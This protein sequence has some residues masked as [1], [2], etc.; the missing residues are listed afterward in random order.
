MPDWSA[1]TR[2]LEP[3]LIPDQHPDRRR[4]ESVAGIVD[5]WAVRDDE[6]DVQ[7]HRDVDVVSWSRNAIY[8]CEFAVRINRHVHEEVQVRDDVAFGHSVFRQFQNEVFTAGVLVFGG[9]A[10]THRVALARATSGRCVMPPAG[11][12]RDMRH[13]AALVGD[14]PRA[15][16]DIGRTLRS[17]RVL[18]A[19]A[20]RR[21]GKAI[22]QRVDRL[23]AFA[24]DDPQRLST[25][26]HVRPGPF[27]GDIVGVDSARNV[28]RRGCGESGHSIPPQAYRRSVNWKARMAS[29]DPVRQGSSAAACGMRWRTST[30][31]WAADGRAGSSG[32]AQFDNTRIAFI[33]ARRSTKSPGCLRSWFQTKQP[34]SSSETGAKNVTQGGMSRTPSPTSAAPAIKLSWVLREAAPYAASVD[35]GV[36]PPTRMSWAP[37]VSSITENNTRPMSDRMTRPFETAALHC[38]LTVSAQLIRSDVSSSRQPITDTLERPDGSAIRNASPRRKRTI[39]YQSAGISSRLIT[40]F[41]RIGAAPS[42][43]A[44]GSALGVASCPAARSSS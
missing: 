4:I 28:S 34:F 22:K 37:L 16:V 9:L 25:L 15:E 44:D 30:T 13:H 29:G 39:A 5:L 26:Q 11:I 31:G 7:V 23:L 19:V 41:S 27:R 20:F 3:I 32:C 14:Q 21:V 1:S 38:T 24:I 2:G 6:N 10:E 36:E 42:A 35:A 8:H 17:Q 40:A 12:G 18:R 43:V 33:S